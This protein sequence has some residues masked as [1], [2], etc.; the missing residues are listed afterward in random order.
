M[1]FPEPLPSGPRP[2]PPGLDERTAAL[3]LDAAGRAA[4][5]RDAGELA[6]VIAE[7]ARE[8]V[9]ADQAACLPADPRTGF[10]PG[11]RE[12][13]LAVPV[14]G[15]DDRPLAVLVVQR[16]PGRPAF[17]EADRERL[18]L[19][20]WQAGPALHGRVL[21]K[22]L[23]RA[24]PLD[25][26]QVP[27]RPAAVAHRAQGLGDEGEL[28]DAS[29]PWR[30]RPARRSAAG[31]RPAGGLRERLRRLAKRPPAIP[32]VRQTAIS[33]CGAA[34]LAMVLGW[35]GRGVRL[36]SVRQRV[37]VTLQGAHAA[38]LLEA[39]SSYGLRGRGVRIDDLETL[40]LL[41]RGS[42]LHWRFQHFVVFDRCDG[43]GGA[44]IVDPA[45]GRRRVSRQE[46]DR[47]F[48]GVALTFEKGEGFEPGEPERRPASARR[49]L[50][51]LAG[52]GLLGRIL[53]SSVLLR[54]L[55]LAVPLLL[56][57]VVDRVVPHSAHR[58]LLV[59]AAGMAALTLAHF[60]SSLVPSHLLLRLRTAV[61]SRMTSDFLEHLVA[62]PFSFFQTRSVGDLL[63][64]LNSHATVRETLTTGVLSG[65]LD[66]A[67]VLI[68]LA[69][70]LAADWRLG[71][72]V[73]GLG[74]VRVGLFLAN[75]RRYRDQMARSLEAEAEAN[76][77]QAQLLVGIETYKAIGAEARALGHWSYLY[78]RVLNAALERGRL[79]A[80]VDAL[81]GALAVG[82]PLLVLT[83]G[84]WRVLEGDLTLGT[85]LAL[86]ALATGFLEPLT[87]LVQI[88]FQIQL[89]GGYL[90]RIDDIL[91]MPREQEPGSATPAGRLAGRITLAGVGFR[92]GPQLPP[93]LRDV[94]VDIPAGSFVALVGRSGA[95]KTTLAHLLLGLHRPTEGT[96]LYDGAD[97]AALDLRSVRQQIGIVPQDPDLLAGSI[98]SNI[99]LADP[100][101][102]LHRVVEAARRAH[103][104]DDILAL[105]MGYEALVGEAGAGLSGGQRQRLALARALL[106]RPRI[107]LLDE[108]TSALDAVTEAKIQAE[109]EALDCTRIVIAHRLST[110]KRADPILVLSGGRVVEQG[111]H[112]TLLSR[113]G[114]YADLVREQMVAPGRAP[115]P[116]PDR[117]DRQIR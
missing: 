83:V 14:T 106:Q 101:Q 98:R 16:G 5:Q 21:E 43:Q 102:P 24:G 112:D 23:A 44:W 78:T 31:A 49:Y 45:W 69:M 72:I 64:R 37:G 115:R 50:R 90:D 4:V 39:A 34:C 26:R 42:I 88:G 55:A 1:S 77:F 99:A 74:V 54:L 93:V 66:G 92:Y 85:M 27:Y 80:R 28:V 12:P 58:L 2:G 25:P 73:L 38:G 62:L 48:T 97:L 60:S 94:S 86:S 10:P 56:A 59:T 32:F 75:G 30:R 100:A 19:L 9:A 110:I 57:V 22:R 51:A 67:L 89:L 76:A 107:L 18:A 114:L 91:E 6:A 36:E 15:P 40:E 63:L 52:S 68:Y 17:S 111:T 82:S 109:L 61:D 13:L 33:D 11:G 96:I 104:H 87:Q 95:G 117:V 53:L 41:P 71:L 79:T 116:G 84:A 3:L 108:A 113:G 7:A 35:H 103:L 81:L 46:L 65:V 29:P 20:A 47:S 70:I 8:L 105:P